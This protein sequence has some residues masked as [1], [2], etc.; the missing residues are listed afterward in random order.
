MARALGLSAGSVSQKLHN[1]T[2]WSIKDVD[3]LTSFFDVGLDG[4][5][6]ATRASYTTMQLL[7]LKTREAHEELTGMP[8]GRTAT[9][10]SQRTAALYA[11]AA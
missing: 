11:L 10:E 9:H 2:H 4:L 5:F 6:D 1:K 8:G 7:G 3:G